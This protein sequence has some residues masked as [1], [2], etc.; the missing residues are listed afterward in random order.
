MLALVLIETVVPA[1]AAQP[2]EFIA[3]IRGGDLAR[4]K[5]LVEGNVQLANADLDLWGTPLYVAIQA[6]QLAIVEYLISK[7][8][9]VNLPAKYGGRPLD[10]ADEVGD[11]AIVRVLESKGARFMPLTFEVVT[12]TP[13]IHR[14]TFPWGM[15]N[16]IVAF[17]GPDGVLLIDSG[18][19]KRAVPELKKTIAGFS[20][21][22]IRYVIATHLHG[23]HTAGNAIAPSEAAVIS[24][25]TLG[26]S[27]K[28]LRPEALPLKGRTG[29]LLPAPYLMRFNGDELKL[30][31]RPGLH[32]ADDLIIY[33]PKSRVVAMGD[34]LLS[35]C[36][37]ASN[38]VAGYMAFLD[39]VIDVF[40]D[41]TTF[42]SGHGK[43][44]TYAGLT[45]YRDGLTAM[46]D[47][48]RKNYAAGK[49][50]DDMIRDD[51]LK[52]FKDEYSFLWIG[53][54]SWIPRVVRALQS[55]ELK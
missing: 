35:Q 38:D 20:K 29:R 54:D 28:E 46:T 13:D 23:D 11:P 6:R 4:V 48:V 9:D 14:I 2:E 41:G 39:D 30:I 43:D 32:S 55:G 52:A 25:Q 24:A 53:P 18:F 22:G 3:A 7:G 49:S 5:V 33:F 1:V 44:L 51:V 47:I 40:A 19:V 36:L 37:P 8:A 15:R 10:V 50:A 34:L 12:V 45:R 17:S 16:N 21:G 42:I 31:P 26:A 27:V